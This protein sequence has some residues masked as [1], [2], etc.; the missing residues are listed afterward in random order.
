MLQIPS[1]LNRSLRSKKR[2]THSVAWI[3]HELAELVTRVQ[4]AVGPPFD[5]QWPPEWVHEDSALYR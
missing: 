5:P 2:W 4:I 3:S 1:G